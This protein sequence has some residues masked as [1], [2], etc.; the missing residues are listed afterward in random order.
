MKPRIDIG[1]E[2][3]KEILENYNLG[4]YKSHKRMWWSIKNT[5]YLLTTSKGKFILKVFDKSSFKETQPTLHIRE[6][7]RRDG[8]PIPE[9][10]KTKAGNIVY[11]Y[12]KNYLTI[13][14]FV[15]DEKR[16]EV[17]VNYVKDLAKNLGLIDMNLIRIKNRQIPARLGYQFNR[18]SYRSDDI[19]LDFDYKSAEER[20]ID[21]TQKNVN[22]AKLRKSIIHSDFT[23][24][25]LIFKNKRIKAVLDWDELH[26][27]Y[28]VSDPAIA[29][30]HIITLPKRIKPEI[31]SS[32]VKEYNKYIKL[33][34]EEEK[35]M[36]YFIK[37]RLLGAIVWCDL[38]RKEHKDKSNKIGRWLKDIIS[39]YRKFDKIPLKEF[40]KL[41]V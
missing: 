30:S 33:N 19:I 23:S 7:L 40:L 26:K 17:D 20:L 15:K 36:Y 13:Q 8:M 14:R 25:N 16:P 31:I 38:N 2:Q 18:S 37:N 12:N 5:L 22:R 29:L 27:D 24:S 6:E 4:E 28:L 41:I 35:A 34:K 11:K 21:E 10:F 1:R 39:F 3:V 9:T 32:F